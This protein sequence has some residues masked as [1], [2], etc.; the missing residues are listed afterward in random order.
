MSRQRIQRFHMNHEMLVLA[1]F[2]RG[3]EKHEIVGAN[4]IRPKGVTFV[5]KKS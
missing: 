4:G 1:G 2:K 5:V 3:H